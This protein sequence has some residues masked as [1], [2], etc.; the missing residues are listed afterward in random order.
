VTVSVLACALNATLAHNATRVVALKNID[1]L[2]N[3]LDFTPSYYG[4]MTVL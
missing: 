4:C 1:F 2:R 3:K